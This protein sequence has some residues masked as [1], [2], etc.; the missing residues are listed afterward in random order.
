MGPIGN[1]KGGAQGLLLYG[2]GTFTPDG[3]PLG[4]GAGPDVGASQ[5]EARPSPSSY[6]NRIRKTAR[7]RSRKTTPSNLVEM[8]QIAIYDASDD[9]VEVRVDHS[10]VWLSQR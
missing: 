1:H 4:S 9:T 6:L 10:T 7:E 3:T 5:G 2:T 8:G